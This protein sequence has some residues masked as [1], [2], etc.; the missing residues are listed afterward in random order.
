MVSDQSMPL[1]FLDPELELRARAVLKALRELRQ[2][3]LN[4]SL[5]R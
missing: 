1:A 4:V 2:R 5:K 3:P